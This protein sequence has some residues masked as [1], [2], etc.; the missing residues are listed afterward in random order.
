LLRHKGEKEGGLLTPRSWHGNSV[1]ERWYGMRAHDGVCRKYV[2]TKTPP[3]LPKK[4]RAP[5]GNVME[6]YNSFCHERVATDE[7]IYYITHTRAHTPTHIKW[8]FPSNS[9]KIDSLINIC[10]PIFFFHFIP[11]FP[12]RDAQD[13]F[14]I[15]TLCRRFVYQT[16]YNEKLFYFILCR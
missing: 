10:I 16:K 5:R 13:K 1:G 4:S 3:F 6:M 2:E 7:D 15:P 11:S 9:E 12:L 8:C 14:K